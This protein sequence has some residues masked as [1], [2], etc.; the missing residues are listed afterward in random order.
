MK[1][2]ESK[3]ANGRM[4][5]LCEHGVG[6]G[7]HIHGCDGCCSDP[8]FPG[9]DYIEGDD[10]WTSYDGKRTRVKDLEDSHLVNIVK[11]LR[12][13]VPEYKH[14]VI[15]NIPARAADLHEVTAMKIEEMDDEDFLHVFSPIYRLLLEEI[16]KRGLE[17]DDTP[18]PDPRD[19]KNDLLG[20]WRL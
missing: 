18:A 14:R 7:N 8:S 3:R 9:K 6:H 19:H 17:I 2:K 11:F 20:E 13:N 12:Q 10:V 16:D 5:W 4:E 15:M 1:W